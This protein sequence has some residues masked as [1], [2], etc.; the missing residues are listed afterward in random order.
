MPNKIRLT[1]QLGHSHEF[2][3]RSNEGGGDDVVDEEGSVVRQEDAVPLEGVVR[4][5]VR[6]LRRS[7]HG[8]QEASERGQPDGGPENKL[9]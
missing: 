1:E 4:R 3:G 8:L 9:K 7:D 6:Q 5:S 2:K